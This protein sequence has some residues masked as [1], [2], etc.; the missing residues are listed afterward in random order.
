MHRVSTFRQLG[1]AASLICLLTGAAWAGCP[2][3]TCQQNQATYG[4][5]DA[6][7]WYLSW[8]SGCSGATVC[9]L[10]GCSTTDGCGASCLR[11]SNANEGCQKSRPCKMKKWSC[12]SSVGGCYLR[13]CIWTLCSSGNCRN[14]APQNRPCPS[15]GG[16]VCDAHGS[17][18]GSVYSDLSCTCC[19][20]LT[21]GSIC[22]NEAERSTNVCFAKCHFKG[23][24]AQNCVCCFE[25]RW[26]PIPRVI[27][28]SCALACT[29]CCSGLGE[30]NCDGVT[31]G[32]R[33]SPI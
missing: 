21:C 29:L 5:P 22:S 14:K 11:C 18:C 15:T 26:Q 2:D 23:S 33:W 20:D 8:C 24:S 28:L 27:P 19:R 13:K 10:T 32:C 16:R 30:S 7:C 12:R 9:G 3:Q 1:L 4:C 31:G 25:C 17:G 6:Y